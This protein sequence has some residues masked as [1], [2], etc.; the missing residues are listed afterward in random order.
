[1]ILSCPA[2]P[3][4]YDVPPS[5]LPAGGRE[6]ECSACGTVW[7]EHGRMAHAVNAGAAGADVAA[8][9]PADVWSDVIDADFQA[10]GPS[11]ARPAPAAAERDADPAPSPARDQQTA[12]TVAY[13]VPAEGAEP[14]P[15]TM[16]DDAAREAARLL[17]L[18]AAARAKALRDRVLV[19]AGHA[20]GT[21]LHTVNRWRRRDGAAVHASPGD[22]AAR[23]TR[24]RMRAKAANAL[25]PARA[26]GWLLWCAA[27]AGVVLLMTAGR[28]VL[29]SAFPPAAKIYA[30]G[31]PLPAAAGLKVT[32]DL[33]TYAM[34]SEGPAVLVAGTIS[35]DGRSAMVPVLTMTVATPDGPAAQRVA[36]PPVA[37]PPGG[38]RPFAVRALMPAGASGLTLSVAPGELE[39]GGFALQETGSGWGSPTNGHAGPPA[40]GGG[41]PAAQPR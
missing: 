36:I 16:P 24:A 7:F 26:A 17:A 41:A 9:W 21:V 27:A 30:L 35:N 15:A 14:Q 10:V 6:V 4:T 13:G 29:Q 38:E 5:A 39:R 2:C 19:L 31:T 33:K 34:S 22:A 1:M 25:T 40:I 18:A 11:E 28:D 32:G 20:L 3:K 12:L 23:A 8:V 37:L